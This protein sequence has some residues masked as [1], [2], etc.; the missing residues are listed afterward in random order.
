MTKRKRVVCLVLVCLLIV[1]ASITLTGCSK[2]P[3]A[4]TRI[5]Y[6]YAMIRFPDGSCVGGPIESYRSWSDGY[7]AV[8]IDGVT[9]LTHPMNVVLTKESGK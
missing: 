3:I 6:Q 2:N 9:Y 7:M 5:G 8:T 1:M 4:Q